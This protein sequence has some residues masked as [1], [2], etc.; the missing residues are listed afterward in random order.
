[1]KHGHKLSQTP[2]SAVSHTWSP[3][4]HWSNSMARLAWEVLTEK[5]WVSCHSYVV[6]YCREYYMIHLQFWLKVLRRQPL[7]IW[8]F[9]QEA[10]S[11]YKYQVFIS[12]NLCLLP[13]VHTTNLIFPFLKE[14]IDRDAFGWSQSS[15]VSVPKDEYSS[16]SHH[17]SN[18]HMYWQKTVSAT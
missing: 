7:S 1:M 8:S 10:H 5:V 16:L 2:P 13:F 14:W 11:M 17:R 6:N 15:E 18:R 4:Y 3:L 9:I 12:L